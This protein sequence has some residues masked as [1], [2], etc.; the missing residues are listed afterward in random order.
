MAV[1][2]MLARRL[3]AS[4]RF[5]D[6]SFQAQA[7][8]FHLVMQAD[9]DGFI[10]NARRLQRQLGIKRQ[11]LETLEKE[12]WLLRFESGVLVI[13]DWRIHNRIRR[14]RYVP[15]SCREE[16]AQLWLDEEERYTRQET[17]WPAAGVIFGNQP[18]PQDRTG[19]DREGQERE[20][21]AGEGQGTEP[22]GGGI[23][24]RCSRADEPERPRTAEQIFGDFASGWGLYPEETLRRQ[25]RLLEQVR[26]LADSLCLSFARRRATALELGHVL[27]CCYRYDEAS[28]LLYYS[29]EDG[30]L[31]RYA[32]EQ[33]VNAGKPGEWNYVL[34]TLDRLRSRGILCREE[35]EDEE[36]EWRRRKF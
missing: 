30:G 3:I 28:G 15:T 23:T 2:R 25:P 16:A 5:M 21:Q 1:R 7:L 34:G 35:A 22:G 36:E 24:S 4:D 6:L 17:A 31:L 27:H 11:P 13:V 33:S 29:E 18:A 20:R 32:F 8:Y 26:E 10:T 9:D 14:D 12:G 19:Q